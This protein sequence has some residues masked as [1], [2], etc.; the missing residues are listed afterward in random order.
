MTLINAGTNH[1]AFAASSIFSEDEP[2]R[3]VVKELIEKR[4]FQDVREEKC[5]GVLYGMALGD[6]IGARLEFKPV[7]Y[8]KV[9]LNGMGDSAIDHFDL[10][11]GQWT[12]DT[13]M[14][15]CLCDSLLS[16]QGTLNAHDLM[17]RFLAWWYLGYN[18]AFR[19]DGKKPSIGLGGN[20]S[21]S[22]HSYLNGNSPDGFTTAGDSQTSG[23]GSVMRLGAVPVCY[24]DN[25]VLAQDVAERQSRTTHRGD[26]AAECCRLLTFLMV[27]LINGQNLKDCLENLGDAF[28]SPEKSVQCLAKNEMENNDRDRNWQWKADDFKYSPKRTAND[29]GYIGSY[30]M[31]AVAMALHCVWTTRSA[32]DA[33]LKAVNLCGDAD[34]VGAV[35]GQIAGAA[36]GFSE[37]PK[38]WIAAVNQ[39]DNQEIGLRAF[40]LCHK[41]WQ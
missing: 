15:L 7:R 30:A 40:Y 35:A 6:A 31:D 4:N 11:P 2:H 39:W 1:K 20:I 23:N 27:N 12:D 21:L 22:F 33:I 28:T 24:W 3:L 32:K 10:K 5:F 13:S 37:F 9:F 14:G 19:F 18:N 16:N 29:P 17:Q 8:G 34:S 41:I 36:Y 38:E 26:E 25:L